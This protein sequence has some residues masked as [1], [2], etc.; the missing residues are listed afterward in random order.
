MEGD[1]ITM[2][3]IF[4]Y[5]LQG[6]DEE[7][8]KTK[9]AFISTGIRPRC[10]DKIEAHGIRLPNHLFERHVHQTQVVETRKFE[11][12][13]TQADIV[14]S[15]APRPTPEQEIKRNNLSSQKG[16]GGFA[17]LRDRLK[18]AS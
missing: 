2:Q 11:E 6:V 16:I 14:G 15:S 9:G 13:E 17:A 10:Y 12:E 8:G 18:R 5:Q 7:T 4:A 1:V 3:E